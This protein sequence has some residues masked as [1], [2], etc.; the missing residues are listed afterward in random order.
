MKRIL[1]LVLAALTIFM[2]SCD[3][4]IQDESETD[5]VSDNGVNNDLEIETNEHGWNKLIL[6]I[7]RATVH[8]YEKYEKFMPYVTNELLAAAEKKISEDL[9]ETAS[10]GFI[11]GLDSEGYLVLSKEVIVDLP[12]DQVDI[13]KACGDHE[14]RFYS[15]RISTKTFTDP[16]PSDPDSPQNWNDAYT[17]QT[18]NDKILRES[19][20]PIDPLETSPGELPPVSSLRRANQDI[21]GATTTIDFSYE[22]DWTIFVY[23]FGSEDVRVVVMTSETMFVFSTTGAVTASFLNGSRK[24]KILSVSVISNEDY[25]RVRE[26]FLS[27][28]R[29][30]ETDKAELSVPEFFS[31]EERNGPSASGSVGYPVEAMLVLEQTYKR[32]G[33]IDLLK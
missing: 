29:R 1:A 3:L 9:G 17:V 31:T 19:S 21:V 7:S 28:S 12:L 14:H 15:A 23:D 2:C 20:D 30:I 10:S 25:T 8:I 27:P 16:D 26:A 32:F 13:N 24:A 6:P 18:L 5:T 33:V 11:L 4:A 22:R